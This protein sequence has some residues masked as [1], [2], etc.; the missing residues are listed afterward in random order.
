MQKKLGFTLI[1]LVVVIVIL[2]ILSVTA[3]PKFIDLQSGARQATM[4]GLKSALESASSMTYA[5]AKIE[6]LGDLASEELSSGI[7]IRYGYPHATQTNL[8]LVLDFDED[9][10]WD[11]TGTHPA[12][13]TFTHLNSNDDCNLKYTGAAEDERPDI[14]IDC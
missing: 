9:S 4:N 3:L 2:A 8:R 11:L 6:G 12:A 13:V 1:E 14:T 5:K 7:K 10:D